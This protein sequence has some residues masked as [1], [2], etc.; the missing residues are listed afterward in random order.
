MQF[1]VILIPYEL[2]QLLFIKSLVSEFI[3]FSFFIIP[4]LKLTLFR[5]ARDVHDLYFS[6][7]YPKSK[8]DPYRQ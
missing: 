6:K 1:I 8:N 4:S 2:F 7:L 5:Y 3:S